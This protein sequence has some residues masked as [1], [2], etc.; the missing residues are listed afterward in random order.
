MNYL[1][2]KTSKPMSSLIWIN[3]GIKTTRI[4]DDLLN[5]YLS[6]GWIKGRLNFKHRKN[7]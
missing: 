5:E 1:G 2:I 6:E 4:K 3:D 7:K